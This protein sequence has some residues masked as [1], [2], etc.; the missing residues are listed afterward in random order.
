MPATGPVNDSAG[1]A[2]QLIWDLTRGHQISVFRTS[3]NLQRRI[4]DLLQKVEDELVAQL[5][6]VDPGDPARMS[7]KFQRRE[8]LLESVRAEVRRYYRAMRDSDYA[9]NTEIA[10][11]EAQ[12]ANNAMRAGMAE[13]GIGYNAVSLTPSFIESIAVNSPVQGGPSADWWSRQ[14]GN[15]LFRFN[16]AIGQ[17]LIQGDTLSQLIV[18]VRGGTR[19]GVRVDGIMDTARRNAETLVRTKVNSVANDARMAV[20]RRNADIIEAL[21]H[22]STLDS[23]TSQQCIVRDGLQWTLDGDPI[24]HNVPF[25]VPPVHFNCR[26]VMLPIVEGARDVGGMRASETG[27]VPATETFEEYMTRRGPA[28]QD[29]VLGPTRAQ[30]WRDGEI[31]LTQTLDFTGNPLTIDQLRERAGQ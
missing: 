3:P 24:G 10:A 27:P 31:T 20:Y 9:F 12:F 2:T 18:R 30:M 8:K 13:I 11:I 1:A 29:E 23:R 5:A 17:G 15:T 14:G 25:D 22:S 7:F 19:D 26:S 6:V 4:L 16:E 21:E 28:F